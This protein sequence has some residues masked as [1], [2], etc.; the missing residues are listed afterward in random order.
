LTS[1]NVSRE[2]FVY[3]VPPTASSVGRAVK[4]IVRD[5]LLAATVPID[6]VSVR[7]PSALSTTLVGA[8]PAPR[9]SAV[10]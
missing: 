1:V 6:H 2:L 9:S 3:E 7:V 5:P 10:L 8:G 4:L